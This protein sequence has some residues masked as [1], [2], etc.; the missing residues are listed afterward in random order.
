MKNINI[1]QEAK[2]ES[3]KGNYI[4]A[5]ELFEEC[6]KDDNEYDIYVNIELS[7]LDIIHGDILSAKSR[8]KRCFVVD[9]FKTNMY[10][11]TLDNAGK[12]YSNMCINS[13]FVVYMKGLETLYYITN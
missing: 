10:L 4:R 8:I 11:K 9:K 13:E 1:F 2:V 5:R 12:K 3:I 7:L 6:E